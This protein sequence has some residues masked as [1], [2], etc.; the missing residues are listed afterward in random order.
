MGRKPTDV[1]MAFMPREQFRQQSAF[2]RVSGALEPAPGVDGAGTRYRSASLQHTVAKEVREALAREGKTVAQ[3]L[4]SVSDARGL[5]KDRVER[6]LRGE[7]GMQI[8]DLAFWAQQFP[9]IA[10]TLAAHIRSWAS[11][12]STADTAPP[13]VGHVDPGNVRAHKQ[14]VPGA[15]TSSRKST[16]MASGR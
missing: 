11:S 8:A 10:V 3:I 16:A 15:Q 1:G 4:S 6:K 7:V 2:G 9:D 5:S 12:P 13:V 14:Q